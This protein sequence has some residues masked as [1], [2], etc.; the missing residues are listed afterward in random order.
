M[1]LQGLIKKHGGKFDKKG[2]FTLKEPSLEDAKRI[3]AKGE[4]EELG[5]RIPFELRHY[6]DISPEGDLIEK[7]EIPQELKSLAEE[8]RE[9]YRR[10]VDAKNSG[11]H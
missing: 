9:A 8:T 7:Q 10:A 5:F 3:A 6:L 11:E 2:W 1:G 4:L